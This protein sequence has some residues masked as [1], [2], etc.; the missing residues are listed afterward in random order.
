MAF[1]KVAD[2]SE[3]PPGTMKMFVLVEKEILVVNVDGKHYAMANRCTHARGSLSEGKLERTTVTC[4]KHGSKFD[5][6]SGK[7]LRGPKIAFLTLKTSDEPVYPVKIE[8]SSILV[9]I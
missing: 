2:V 3:V 5:V 1:V 8:G 6:T 7:S 9:D 4:P